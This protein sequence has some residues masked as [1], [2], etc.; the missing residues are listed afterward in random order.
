MKC[1]ILAAGYATRLYPLTEK[2]PKPL[3]EINGKK[4][5]DWL[6]DDLNV[7]GYI[8]SFVV[9]SNHKFFLDFCYWA[10]NKKDISVLDDGSTDNEN[11]LGA[12][13]D[14]LYAI[15]KKDIDDDILVIAGDN[16][17]DFSLSVLLKHSF[18]KDV[19]GTLRYFE[20]DERI[21][22][23][24][25]VAVIDQDGIIKE[26]K[27]KSDKP[28]ANWIIPPFYVIKRKDVPFVEKAIEDGCNTDAPGSLIAWMCKRT[29]I[30]SIEMPGKRFDIGDINS[31]EI[32]QREYKGLEK[33]LDFFCCH[34]INNRNRGEK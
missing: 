25:G 29:T 8:D 3:L 31:Y 32:A 5:L 24:S 23:K 19:S 14:I 21:L 16:V 30:S 33:S 18:D 4:I 22:K 27:E 11:R 28:P 7:S 20:K 26:M 9:V 10:E 12:G 34:D 17:L 1:I 2:K 6:Y 15:E 13:K